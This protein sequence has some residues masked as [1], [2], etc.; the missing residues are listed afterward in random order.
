MARFRSVKREIVS[1][2]LRDDWQ[3]RIESELAAMEAQ[4]IVGPLFSLLLHAKAE[5][6]WRAVTALGATVARMADANIESARVVMRRFMWHMNEESGNV[7]WG[8]PESMAESMARHDQLAKEFHKPLASYVQCPDCIGDDN[9]LDHPPLRQAVYWGL[10]RLAQVHPR[11]AAQGVAEL[12]WALT[13]EE[14]PTSRAIACWALSLIGH[15]ESIPVIQTLVHDD[16][17]VE[18]YRDG[19]IEETTLGTLAAESL[20]ALKGA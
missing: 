10:A 19:I 17:P 8:I 6:R 18:L 11:Y 3:E 13:G 4:G 12:H 7:G 14:S 2:L 5:V 9:Y 1:L 16:S 15:E 20:K